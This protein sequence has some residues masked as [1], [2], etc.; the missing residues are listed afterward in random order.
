MEQ[1]L[2]FKNSS[3]CKLVGILSIPPIKPHVPIVVSCHGFASGKNSKT[4]RLLVQKLNDFGIASFRFDFMGHYDS[5]GDIAD[6]TISQGVD[7]LKCALE[8]IRAF[9]RIDLSN[10]GLFGASYGGNVV[11]WYAGSKNGVKAIA[12]KAPVCDYAHVRYLQLGEKGINDW[13][14]K[15]FTHVEGG[16]EMVRTNYQF[17]ED[18]KS[19]DTY[20]IAK[21]I[22]CDVLIIHGGVDD[23]VPV[24]QSRKLSEIIGEKAKFKLIPNANHGFKNL[25][26]L[27]KVIDLSSTFF[28]EKLKK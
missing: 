13:K 23:N 12:L 27:E 6:V 21:N 1:E 18:A 9:N 4:N 2:I 16:G 17:Y 20:E 7:D 28:L 15:G 26:E 22:T 11:L 25:G 14:T 3:G 8:A 24:E 5:E 10:L 19:I